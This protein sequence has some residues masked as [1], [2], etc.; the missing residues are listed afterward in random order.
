MIATRILTLLFALLIAVP[1]ARAGD[2]AFRDILGFSPDGKYFA[3]EEYG[4]QDGSG[5]PYSNIFV[6]DVATDSWADGTPIRRRIDDE[7]TPLSQARGEARAKADPILKKLAVEPRG[8]LVVS[9]PATEL[10]ADP[11]EV[12]FRLNAFFNMPERAWNLRLTPITVPEPA[13]ACDNLGPVKGLKL[14]LTSPE[15]ETRVI[16]QDKSIPESR[17]CPRDYA[18]SD[19]VVF[20]PESGETTIAVLLSLFRQGFEGP[21]RRFIA[22]TTRV[23]DR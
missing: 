1:M 10:S 20:T 15:G 6:I 18:I 16:A 14:E 17:F 8:L 23:P 9:N 22:V 13:A 4:V 2:Y 19:V 21:D 11:Y 7:A 3:F 12:R 5:F